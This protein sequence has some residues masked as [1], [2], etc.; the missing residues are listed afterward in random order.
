MVRQ[1]IE[2]LFAAYPGSK[3]YGLGW[4]R[5]SH[6]DPIK[7]EHKCS[8]FSIGFV[9]KKG[10]AGFEPNT[11]VRFGAPVTLAGPGLLPDLLP[12]FLVW[13][14]IFDFMMTYRPLGNRVL[15]RRIVSVNYCYRTNY[16]IF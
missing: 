13:Q 8:V 16:Q 4:G 3:G 12:R 9:D 6:R 5:F 2:G 1:R 11:R 7:T 14:L 10:V 15:A